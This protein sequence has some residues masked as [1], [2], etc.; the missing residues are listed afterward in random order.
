MRRSV[1]T[2]SAISVSANVSASS[3]YPIKPTSLLTVEP[4]NS[5]LT[6]RSVLT[7]N[8]SLHTFHVYVGGS[9]GRHICPVVYYITPDT[10]PEIELAILEA[11]GYMK[12]HGNADDP[13]NPSCATGTCSDQVRNHPRR[14]YSLDRMKYFAD[15]PKQ[16]H[17]VKAIVI[18]RK[19]SVVTI[20][21][22]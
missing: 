4:W 16:Q 1:R 21:G 22:V 7:R 3:R 19:L 6:D 18:H 15:Q 8:A 17:G 12:S 2:S 5:S 20:E 13:S 11:Q 9:L 14:K 10:P